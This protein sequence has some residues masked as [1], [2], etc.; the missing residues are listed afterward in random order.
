VFP[1][2]LPS[3]R[4]CEDIFEQ[5]LGHRWWSAPMEAISLISGKPMRKDSSCINILSCVHYIKSVLSEVPYRELFDGVAGSKRFAV[6]DENTGRLVAVDKQY[7]LEPG[8]WISNDLLERVYRNT[9]SILDDP[10]AIYKAGRN[11]FKTAVGSQ[12]FLMRLAGV[13]TI[14][15]RLPLE[16]AK[17]NQNRSIKIVKNLNGFALVRI[18]WKDDPGISKH[19]CDMN[20]GVYE[21][22]G[23]LTGNPAAVKESVCQFE[24][25]NFCEYRISWK[26]KPFY[27]RYLDLIRWRMSHEIIEELERRIEEVNTIRLKQEKTIEL[28]TKDLQEQKRIVDKAHR[29]LARYVPAQLVRKILAGEVEPLRDHSRRKLTLFFSDIKDF[30]RTTDAMEPEDM[31]RLLNEYFSCMNAIIQ[32]YEGTLAN[33]TGDALFVFFGAPDR[34]DDRDHALR[35]VRM[36]LDMQHKMMLLG[37]KWFQEG[38]EYPLQIRCGIN[39]GMAT[40]GSFGSSRRSEYSAMGTQVNLASRLEAACTPGKILIS[41]AT[42]ALVNDEINCRPMGTISVKGFSRPIRVYEVNPD[43]AKES[44]CAGLIEQPSTAK[45]SLDKQVRLR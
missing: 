40:V 17:F 33:I 42:W 11:I 16:N 36:A 10:E 26:A 2:L 7:L 13:Q 19:F 41:H 20:R 1:A 39:T 12:V 28:R 21:G 34:T 31:G 14:I 9:V 22:L 15:N 29:F 25:G 37:Q 45:I 8:N 24:G 32:N 38:I 35:C 6:T 43:D 5:A 27:A 3:R 23:K 18:Y 4:K 44:S 30:T